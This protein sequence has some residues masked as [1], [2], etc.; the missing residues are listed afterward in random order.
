MPFTLS[1][2]A[3]VAPLWPVARRLRLP[4]AALVV[5][6]MAPDVEFFLYLRPEAR[7]SHSAA[8][9]LTFCLPTGLLVYLVWEFAA[10]D[11]IRSLLT[12][13]RSAP[14][15]P[16]GWRRWTWWARVVAALLL[17]AVTHL[18][19]DGVT[20]GGYW[21]AERWPSLRAPAFQVGG[22]AVPWFNLFQHLSTLVGG[23]VVLC[24]LVVKLRRADAFRRVRRSRWRLATLAWLCAAAVA[25][26][27][28]N[29]WRWNRLS[30]LWT[31]QLAAGRMAVGALLGLALALLVFTTAYR[32]RR[33]AMSP[34]HA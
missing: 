1:H 3:A 5:G 26:G 23:A 27:I 28:W 31:V 13:P 11:P 15:E 16:D 8:G 34:P 18:A 12:L 19:W 6:A 33:G 9:L 21:G 10:R 2:P 22:R 24:W 25:M 20:H 14:S 17:G 32:I 29:G 30:S 7:L 4:L